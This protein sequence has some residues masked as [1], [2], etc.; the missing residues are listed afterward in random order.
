MQDL[1]EEAIRKARSLFAQ[2]QDDEGDRARILHK[3]TDIEILNKA[4]LL[5]K[6]QITRT[7]LILLGKK[8]AGYFFD[9]F[10]PRITWTLYNGDGLP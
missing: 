5:I 6:G 7:A 8:E 9:G 10:V 4:G 3:Y 2:K 1:D